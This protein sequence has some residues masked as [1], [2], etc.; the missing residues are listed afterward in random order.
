MT[1]W[2]TIIKMIAISSI[3]C[4]VPYTLV[5]LLTKECGDTGMACKWDVRVHLTK[6]DQ[7]LST[8]LSR[9][10]REGYGYKHP[11]DLRSPWWL[12]SNSLCFGIRL[13]KFLI[14]WWKIFG[15]SQVLAKSV[16]KSRRD[17]LLQVVG[18]NT[19]LCFNLVK[20]WSG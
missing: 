7:L 8:L 11:S 19:S 15:H 16:C 9:V 10:A 14:Q 17:W 18:D 4:C 5:V 12:A 1:K 3:G 6:H 20:P 13:S 2:Y